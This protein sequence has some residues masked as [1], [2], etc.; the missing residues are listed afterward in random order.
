MHGC[1]DHLS[2]RAARIHWLSK[3][4]GSAV[5]AA[6]SVGAGCAGGAG[7]TGWEGANSAAAHKSFRK[8]E[9]L[10]AAKD[11]EST[12]RGAAVLLDLPSLQFAVI[13]AGETP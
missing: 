11:D 1:I 8:G 6:A 7:S 13:N 9:S 5:S 10:F 4:L 12:G 3:T 2:L